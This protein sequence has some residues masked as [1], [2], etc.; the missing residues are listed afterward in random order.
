MTVRGVVAAAVAALA[1]FVAS[2]CG[3]DE[4]GGNTVRWYVFAEPSGAYKQAAADCTKQANGRYKIEIVDLPTNAD[5]QRELVV[6]RLAAKDSDIDIIGMDVIW[7]AEFA[8]A[9]WIKPWTGAA[10]KKAEQGKLAGP[11]KT[12]QYQGKLWAIP[13]TSNTQLLWYRKDRVKTPPKTWD[14]MIAM[15]EK[16]PPDQ[17]KI[18]VQ[19]ARYEGLTVWFNSLVAS[20]GGQIVKENGDVVLGP[21]AEKAA[22]IMKKLA[23]SPVAS[24]SLSNDREDQGRLAFQEGGSSFMLN[25]P[26]VYPSAKAEAPDVFK[27]LGA[28]PWPGVQPGQPARVTVGGI[29]LGVGEYS[30][31]PELA[32]Q[33]A[34]CLASPANQII[35]AQKGGLPPTTE[36]LYADKKIQDAY[37][38]FANLLRAGIDTGVP[39]PVSP[40]YSDIS[41]AIQKSVHPPGDIDPPQAVDDLRGKLDKAAEGKI[42]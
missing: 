19:G 7:T 27:N 29:N 20:A 21:P 13:F 24:A 36:A 23:S 33:A 17:N 6:R 30:K 2:G 28:A 22:G 12:A 18:Q 16:L 32:F 37:P 34:A 5:Q 25:Y 35:A 3:S 11:L 4:G 8:Q 40:A 41:L 26:Y 14:E 15:A 38:G 10:A 9:G 1:L 39:R 42:F 31:K